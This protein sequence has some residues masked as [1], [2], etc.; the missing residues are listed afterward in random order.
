MG[1]VIVC[2][3]MAT[4]S[5]GDIQCNW[6]NDEQAELIWDVRFEQMLKDCKPVTDRVPQHDN[7]QAG[8]WSKCFIKMPHAS[9]VFQGVNTARNVASLSIKY[10]LNEELHDKQ[11]GWKDGRLEQAYGRTTAFWDYSCV[12]ISNAGMEG[13]DLDAT[14]HEGTMREFEIRCPHCRKFHRMR[15]KWEPKEEHLGGLR[16][17][18][19]KYRRDDG[20]YDYTGIAST[21]RFQMPCGGEVHHR[22]IRT[23]RLMAREGRYSEPHNPGAP[24][25][26]ESYRLEAVNVP[27]IDWLE[28]VVQKHGAIKARKFGD[29]EPWLKYLRERECIFPNEDDFP[30]YSS[31][32][33]SMKTKSERPG[34]DDR[35]MR[36]GAFDY[37]HGELAKG[38]LPHWWGVIVDVV[39]FPDGKLHLLVVWEGKC[40]GDAEMLDVIERH[41]VIPRAVVCDSG[42]NATHVYDVCLRSGFHAIKGAPDASFPHKVEDPHTGEPTIVRKIYSHSQP[43]HLMNNRPPTREH[44]SLEPLFWRYSKLAIADRYAWLQSGGNGMVKLEIPADVSDDFV[45]HHSAEELQEFRKKQTNQVERK[46]VKVRKRNDLLVCMRYITMMLEMAGLIGV[47]ASDNVKR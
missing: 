13:S 24:P 25:G 10:Q 37:Q 20:S 4:K 5:H 42:H 14:F 26:F 23:R 34:L 22:D 19:D 47:G 35:L 21:L 1:E 31:L 44:S 38:E 29:A 11:G 17:D 27:D 2:F 15:T 33:L 46:W 28:L 32:N 36:L 30:F 3:W 43:L 41:E 45:A 39:R 6:Q 7:R 8:N 16:Y 18:G 40:D 12:N 9:L